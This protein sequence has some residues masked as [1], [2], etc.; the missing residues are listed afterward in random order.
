MQLKT[1]KEAAAL[2][3]IS[4]HKLQRDRR[5]GSP[6]RFRKIGRSVRYSLEDIV[7]FV[8]AQTFTSTTAY[9]K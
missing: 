1:E 3:G 4:I 9:K 2:L 7:A 6:L 8:E 5:I